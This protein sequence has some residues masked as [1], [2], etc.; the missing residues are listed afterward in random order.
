MSNWDKLDKSVKPDIETVDAFVSFPLWTELRSYLEATYQ[1]KPLLE[2]SGC[3]VPGWN[4]KYRK[5]GRGL[6]TLYP[7]EGWFIALVV[8]GER[9]KEEAE[10]VLPTL[11]PY[12]Q[13][14]YA[15][16]KEGMGQRW[17]MTEVRNEAVLEDV[18]KLI[19]IRRGTARQ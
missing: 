1:S 3:S 16:T 18:K 14:L 12:L 6:C 19:A 15:E 17:L 5:S 9:E 2:Y 10:L 11:S 7:M 13:K 8:I 4:V